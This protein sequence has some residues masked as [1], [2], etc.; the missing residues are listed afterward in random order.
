MVATEQTSYN[1][2]KMQ[3]KNIICNISEGFH[4]ED[5]RRAALDLKMPEHLL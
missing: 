1:K 4:T 2:T 3:E 5:I